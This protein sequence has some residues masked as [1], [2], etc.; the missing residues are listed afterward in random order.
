MPRGNVLMVKD[1]GTIWTMV[2]QPEEGGLDRVVFDWRQFAHF[3]EGT[4]GR[5]FYQDYCFGAGRDAI[6]SFLRG[7]TLSVEHEEFGERI[8]FED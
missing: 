1:E 2:Y 3:Y 8:L 5:S 7:K 4:S 6:R